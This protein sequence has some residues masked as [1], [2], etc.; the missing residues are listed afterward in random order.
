MQDQLAPD[1]DPEDKPLDFSQDDEDS[2]AQHPDARS[3]QEAADAMREMI[4]YIARN[5]A[6]DKDAVSVS[7]KLNRNHVTLALSAS[8]ED[9][10][11]IIGRNGRIAESIRALLRVAAI[12]ADLRARL[13]IV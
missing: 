2:P 5:L 8:D 9:K 13:E 7:M 3:K 10:G 11:R 4:S 6:S 1:Q 12:K